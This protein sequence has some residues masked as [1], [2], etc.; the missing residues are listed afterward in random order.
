M[1]LPTLK[2]VTASAEAGDPAACFDLARLYNFGR[3]EAAKDS[4]QA[5]KWYERAAELG[6]MEACLWIGKCYMLGDDDLNIPAA[7]KDPASAE[8]AIRLF[9]IGV[10]A[11]NAEAECLLA[12]MLQAKDGYKPHE[13][14]K[15]RAMELMASSAAK[16]FLD[17][18][19]L[20]S[21]YYLNGLLVPRDEA[22]AFM[23]AQDFTL[24]SAAKCNTLGAASM[25]STSIMY[26]PL[27]LALGVGT[28]QDVDRA[29]D[30][31]D[32]LARKGFYVPMD[33]LVQ[34]SMR[35]GYI[36]PFIVKDVLRPDISEVIKIRDARRAR[37]NP[38]PYEYAAFSEKN[39]ISGYRNL[40]YHK[41][42]AGSA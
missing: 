18:K 15:Q 25:T 37:D 38:P 42:G 9:E 13:V 34:G 8:N 2:E 17:A 3:R 26:Y 35:D 7:R 32:D 19:N 21:H 28:L 40:I 33:I 11:G 36:F 20:L 39:D 10:K 6:N 16:G 24:S 23:H 4:A 27:F 5:V 1:G 22:L 31:M 29:Y 41:R 14:I 30:V 12:T